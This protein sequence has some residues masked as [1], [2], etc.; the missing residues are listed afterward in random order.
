MRYSLLFMGLLSWLTVIAENDEITIGVLAFRSVEDTQQRFQIM[1]EYLNQTLPEH[2]V[3]ILAANYSDLEALIADAKI[4]FVLT[5]PSHYIELRRSRNFSGALA[6]MIVQD[7]GVAVNSFG[8]VMLT[9]AD[10]PSIHTLTDLSGQHIAAVSE[11]SLGGYRAQAY[12]LEMAGVRMSRQVNLHFT[13]MPHDKVL[14]LVL[15]G[16]V[17]AGFL[18]TGVLEALV[19]ANALDL[20]ALRII[21]PNPAGHYPFLL[22][23]QLYPEWPLAVLPHVEIALAGEVTAAV[24]QFSP[25]PEQAEAMGLLGFS[26]PV[27]YQPVE[28]LARALRL[29]PFDQSPDFTLSDIW[30]RY[31][32]V[33][34][35]WVLAFTLI[36]VML[37][38]WHTNALHQRQRNLLALIRSW[39]EP[40]V[41][42]EK[43]VVRDA[44]PSA[45]S[46]LGLTQL[47]ELIA[48][49]PA[50]FSPPQQPD[51]EASTT[52]FQRL[53]PLVDA[54]KTIQLEWL[55]Q[56]PQGEA[57][58]VDMTLAPYHENSHQ[59]TLCSWHEI[60]EHKRIEEEL[61]LAA[62]VFTHSREAILITDP[63]GAIIE[64]NQ[65]FTRITG[66]TREEVL[67]KNPRLLKSG[68]QDK[69][70]YREM[71]QMLL[72]HGYWSG[73][74]WNK[75]KCGD[76]YAEMLTICAIRDENRE[77]QHYVALFS[78]ITQQKRQQEKLQHIAH[79]DALT[80]LPNRVLVADR[81]QQ[82]M[83]R[84]KRT[85]HALA[86]A[87]ID[88]D[89]FKDINDTYGHNVGDEL[90]ITIAE[91]MRNTLR[92][93]DTVGR[94]GGDEFVAI[95]IDQDSHD[96]CATFIERILDAIAEPI[97]INEALMQVSGSIGVSF[98]PQ[99]IE[100]EA[101]QLLRQADQAMYQAKISGKNRYHVF[102]QEKDVRIRDNHLEWDRIARALRNDEFVLYYQPKVHMCRGD[103]IG[104]EALIRWQHPEKGLLS[105]AAFLPILLHHPLGIALDQW[106]LEHALQQLT[107]W[108]QQGLQLPVSVNISPQY[109]QHQ[110]FTS[111]LK[112]LLEKYPDL[113]AFSLELEVVETGALEDITHVSR[114]IEQCAQMGV[115]VA[116]DDFGTGYS[117][118]TYLKRLPAKILKID[119]SFVR[120]MYFDTDDLAILEGILGMAYA[121]KRIAV[122]EGVETVLHG[123]LLLKLG[124]E[125]G[126]GYGIARPMPAEQLPAWTESWQLPSKW[127]GLTRL[128]S[129]RIQVLYAQIE[130]RAWIKAIDDYLAG[131][132]GQPEPMHHEHCRLAQWM[133]DNLPNEA[134][135]NAHELEVVHDLHHQV[136]RIGNQLI[137]MH[138]AGEKAGVEIKQRQLNETS[139]KLIEHLNPLQ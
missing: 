63:H 66:Y 26:I 42:L 103:I 35:L 46:L 31:R 24:L 134:I 37:L 139:Q 132:R 28:E 135:I 101:E 20:S 13:G 9:R 45:L 58:V 41:L 30:D 72:E 68:R 112:S 47:D 73:E 50:R 125:I 84:A 80:G 17:D 128:G 122:A 76:V 3:R 23:T 126:Q 67:G 121:F 118:L 53:L 64:V 129:E 29:P 130:H 114:A 120:D 116:L 19:N 102:D 110:D 85:G 105:P 21:N 100:V 78:D 38:V 82:A 87:F 88:L 117:S 70:F 108:H 4:D 92:E 138:L 12:E 97:T 99:D 16:T 33:L 22:S 39:P 86:L 1:G 131:G 60:T 127:R 109:F 83:M 44:N 59:L 32:V 79:F 91:R 57:V 111:Q 43:G 54:G 96:I 11:S 5:N 27:D 56:T 123:E 113:P 89:G 69:R 52:K 77:L 61:R 34:L 15:D 136:H 106:V 104:T 14:E 49:S 98:F 65:S 133:R 75:R 74:V 107:D 119:Q 124:C 95:L 48:H 7:Q 71:W 51:R 93:E 25:T 18:R 62:N 94:L 90:L 10:H 115:N 2:R 137:A 8:G 55:F 40:L 36:I 81:L 6:T